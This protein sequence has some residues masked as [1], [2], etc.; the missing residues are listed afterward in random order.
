[1]VMKTAAYWIEKLGLV[2]HPEGGYYRETH[3]SAE[4]IPGNS[5]PERFT[6]ARNFSTA[7][8]FLL[9]SQD[10]SLFHRIKSDEL[11]HHYAGS[12]LSLYVLNDRGLTRHRLGADPENGESFQVIVPAGSWF[13]AV[14]DQKENFTLSGCTVAPGFDFSDFEFADRVSLL[15]TFPD[16]QH[17][18]ELLTT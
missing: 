18:I 14:V 3:R 17:I 7:I 13:G 4:T 15:K 1:M 8:Y 10:R 16:H 5:L 9:R 6:G 12:S 11:W 2:P